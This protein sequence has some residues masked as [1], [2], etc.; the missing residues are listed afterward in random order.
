LRCELLDVDA[1]II[2]D[3]LWFIL[4][5]WPEHVEVYHVDHTQQ[6]QISVVPPV[7]VILEQVVVGV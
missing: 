7:L 1:G 5:D 3:S 4:F 6:H 2:C